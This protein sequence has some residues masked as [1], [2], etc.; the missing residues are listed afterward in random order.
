MVW[1]KTTSKWTGHTLTSLTSLSNANSANNH[2]NQKKKKGE[3]NNWAH[4]IPS[5]FYLPNPNWIFA[6]ICFFPLK[7]SLLHWKQ[8]SHPSIPPSLKM[9]AH[10]NTE[11]QCVWVWWALYTKYTIFS[12]HTLPFF[13]PVPP[14]FNFD[15]FLKK[16]FLFLN[17]YSAQ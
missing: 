4:F 14:Q 16:K 10:S 7:T 11:R 13:S 17:D 6:H 15:F 8:S 12:H 9:P 3:T 2:T 5:K 1:L